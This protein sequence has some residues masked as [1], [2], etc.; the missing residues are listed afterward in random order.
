MASWLPLE[1]TQ[2]A[3]NTDSLFYI[4][5]GVVTFFFLLVEVLLITFL[6]RYRR[7]KANR[8]GVNVHGNMK[9]EVLWTLIPA[10][11]LVVLGAFSIKYVYADQ[12][13]PAKPLIVKVTG[14]E[15]YWQF[16]YPNG[17]TT[18]NELRVPAGQTVEFQITSAD[19]IHGFYIPDL[20]M[21]Q[22]ALP[23]RETYY[24]ANIKTTD[25]GTKFR[26]PCDQFCGAGHPQM[27][28]QGQV[29]TQSDFENWEQQQKAA[30]NS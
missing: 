6:I 23:G 10:F 2:V 18:K 30:N 20:R 26:I 9:L 5:L 14:H 16:T 28:A 1:L 3:H 27:V 8:V 17:A 15:W 21:Q 7:T 4:M 11:I 12:V 19:V 29:M 22:D 25:V 13:V 24:W